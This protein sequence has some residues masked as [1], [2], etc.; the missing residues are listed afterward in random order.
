[1]FKLR[2]DCFQIQMDD[3]ANKKDRTR[4]SHGNACDL[5]RFISDLD[6]AIYD[7]IAGKIYG[8]LLRIQDRLPHVD[9]GT[10]R[11]SVRCDLHLQGLDP[12]LCFDRKCILLYA[13]DIVNELSDAADAVAAHL[14]FR[15]VR[16]IHDHTSVG[17]F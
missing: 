11:G 2:T 12:A 8:D 3:I 10:V 17:N 1:M 14:A 13:P 15:A 16:V 6:F 9:A 4:V 5:R 7:L